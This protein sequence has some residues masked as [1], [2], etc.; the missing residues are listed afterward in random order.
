LTILDLVAL[1]VLVVVTAHLVIGWSLANGL[2]EGMLRVYPRAKTGTVRVRE[3]SGDRIVLEAPA[4]T[5]EIGHPGLLGIVWDG[6]HGSLGD[7][8]A[9]DG[10]LVTRA[11]R[12][13]VG[14]PP[15]CVGPID[16]CPAVVLDGYYY[17]HGP[18]DVGLEY[19]DT[20]YRSEVGE[21]AAWLVP[22]G[23]GSRWAIMCHGWT[24][25][26][27]ELVRMLPELHRRGWSAL[28][29][30]YRNDPGMPA[31]PT[32]RYRFGVSEW[33]DMESAV[34]DVRERGASEVILVGCSTGGAIVMSFLERSELADEISGVVLDSPNLVLSETVRHGT[35]GSKATRLMIE[36]GM[37]IADLRW[38]IDW[39]S[40]NHVIRAGDYLHVPTLVFHGTSDQTV[41]IVESRALEAR[42]P[43]L[44][45]LVE[46]PAA[47]HVMSW[48]ADPGRYEAYLGNFLDQV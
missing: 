26:R 17:R 36:V 38:R 39:E 37:W 29:I 40:T 9:A 12:E 11:F 31:D 32:G 15:I 18:A 30:D 24:A 48:N 7:V 45:Q 13:G 35:A 47:G 21:M 1:G 6:G 41:P 20:S 25:E 8:V 2:H 19:E 43:D 10:P 3:Q 46:T 42:V 4:P 34:R 27:R 23:D 14:S 44:V 22:G 5:Q 28:V 33:R 16:D